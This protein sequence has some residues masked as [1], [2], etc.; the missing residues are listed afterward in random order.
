[1]DKSKLSDK[2]QRLTPLEKFKFWASLKSMFLFSI[3]AS[4]LSIFLPRT[5][6]WSILHQNKRWKKS[7]MFDLNHGQISLEK[8]KF[9]ALFKSMVFVVNVLNP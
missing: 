2:N 9:F 1:M 6:Y 5:S 8:C 7:F 3:K 4:S